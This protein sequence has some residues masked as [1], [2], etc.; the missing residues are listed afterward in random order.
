MYPHPF[1]MQRILEIVFAALSGCA[2]GYYLVVLL[3][4]VSFLR[5]RRS[6]AAFTPPVTL[7]KPLKGTDPNAYENFRSHVLQ[8]YPEVQIV[9]GVNDASDPAVPLVEQLKR[10]FPDRDIQLVVAERVLGTNRKVSNLAQMLPAAKHP[11][12]LINDGDIR[13]APDY[14]ARVM[15]PFADANIG[16]VTALYRGH[17]AGSFGSRLESFGIATEFTPGVLTARLLE[18]GLHFGLG[19]TLTFRREALDQIGGFEPLAD[20]L[21]D[22]YELGQRIS[23]S[24]KIELSDVVVE[25]MLPPYTLGE[26]WQHELRWGRTQRGARPGGY[27][28]RIVTFGVLWS[29]LAVIAAKGALWAW[30]LLGAALLLRILIA[31]FVGAKV[32]G[33][34]TASVR[35]WMLPIREVFGFCVWAASFFGRKVVWR[36]ES[37]ILRE[38]KLHPIRPS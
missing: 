29:V 15:A 8:N 2:L 30:A 35:L 28:G 12:L 1:R 17:A 26:A 20:Y 38:G 37:F 5:S 25:T 31:L 7:L 34:Q 11:F 18:G 3:A 23:E 22:D 33:D 14:L 32:A 21:A 9:F 6:T 13:V 36:G 24:A 4:A 19:S 16:M 10:E 27:A